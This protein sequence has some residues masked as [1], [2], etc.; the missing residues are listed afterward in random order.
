[1]VHH[2]NMNK[3]DNRIENLA[4]TNRSEHAF[5]HCQLEELAVQFMLKGYVAFDAEKGG[6]YLTAPI[7]PAKLD[8][9]PPEQL[10]CQ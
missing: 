8:E 7:E 4:L 5:W 6:Y 9:E 3:H 2:I 1:M 10:P